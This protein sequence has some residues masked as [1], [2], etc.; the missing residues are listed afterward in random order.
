MCKF[1][2]RLLGIKDSADPS[3]LA[4]LATAQQT[5][6][7][8][9]LA[10]K[11]ANDQAKASSDSASETDQ[12]AKEDRMRKLI[13]AGPFGA[14]LATNYGDAPVASKQLYGSST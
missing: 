5:A 9:L 2:G 14:T 4:A 11:Q 1:L 6:N 12:L 7:N 3:A 10:Q 8:A 13:A